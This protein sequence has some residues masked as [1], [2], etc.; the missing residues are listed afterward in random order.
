MGLAA[1]IH[2]GELLNHGFSVDQVV[3]AYGDVCQ[4]IT[5]LAVERAEPFQ[6]DE[7]RTLNRCLDDSIAYAVTEFSSQRD[8]IVTDNQTMELNERIG[9]LAHE[10][11]NLVHK[12]TLTFG[13]LKAGTVGMSGATSAVMDRTL[14]G[15][16]SLIDR[17]VS[18]VRLASGKMH[19]QVIYVAELIREVKISASLEADLH[20][21][22]FFVSSVDPSL[23]VDADRQLLAAAIGNLLQNAFEF[24]KP[25]TEVILSAYAASDRVLI[26]VADRCGGLPWSDAEKVFVPF[27]EGGTDKR[28]LG[29]GLSISRRSV[30]ANGGTLRVRDRP[31]V[32]CVFTIDLPRHSLQASE[33][34]AH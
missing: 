14:V 23:A 10:L 17:S 8:L 11:R 27:A 26:E 4:S 15:L 29:L 22:I 20:K 5:D 7:F 9:R 21:C 30:E 25:Q 2:G 6:M 3:H 24:T 1:T 31:G 33:M 32:G 16:H 19:N 13:A 28:G 12:A 34:R 18:D